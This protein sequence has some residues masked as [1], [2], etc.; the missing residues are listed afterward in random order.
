MAEDGQLERFAAEA[1]PSLEELTDPIALEARLSEARARRAKVLAQRAAERALGSGTTDTS[2]ATRSPPGRELPPGD[3]APQWQT[4]RRSPPPPPPLPEPDGP[5]FSEPVRQSLDR[6]SVPNAHVPAM[7]PGEAAAREDRSA[8]S[9]GMPATDRPGR[10]AA[11]RRGAPAALLFVA[12]LG[13]GA[14]GVAV[15]LQQGPSTPMQQPPAPIAEVDT[16]A[17]VAALPPAANDVADEP[18]PATTSSPMIASVGFPAGLAVPDSERAPPRM[19]APGPAI[20]DLIAAAG[21]D[22]GSG[23]A[24]AATTSA[25]SEEALAPAGAAQDEIESAALDAEAPPATGSA[26]PERVSI[27]YPDSAEPLAVA[28]REALEAAGVP[29]VE[30]LPVSYVIGRS[31]VR[32]YHAADQAGAEGASTLLATELN[33]EPETRD[34]TDYPTPTASGRIELWL[35]GQPNGSTTPS[36]PAAPV[37]PPPTTVAQA[38]QPEPDPY[39]PLRAVDQVREVQR[40]LIERLGGG[41]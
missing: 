5:G 1:E 25:V 12:G 23:A 9:N 34:F 32:F 35:A 29:V 17:T 7:P 16:P 36:R 27:L 41:G 13:L 22:A 20:S 3:E 4:F 30:T 19:S 8:L 38:P 26:L 2:G 6:A 31:N 11:R 33:G 28:A 39:T 18:G 24:E 14:A 37:A 15:F 10:A 21:A 40:I